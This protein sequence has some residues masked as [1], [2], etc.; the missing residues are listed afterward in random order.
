MGGATKL[1]FPY[2][3]Y[4]IV[5]NLAVEKVWQISLFIASS[6]MFYLPKCFWIASFLAPKFSATI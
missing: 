2:G 1:V 4:C 3:M 6:P 5:Q